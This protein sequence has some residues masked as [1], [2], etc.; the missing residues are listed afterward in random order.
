VRR[1]RGRRRGRTKMMTD[2]VG[3]VARS[4][5]LSA[6]LVTVVGRR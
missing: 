5:G 6:P 1:G 2:D 4:L 3:M